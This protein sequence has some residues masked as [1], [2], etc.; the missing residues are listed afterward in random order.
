MLRNRRPLR[1]SQEV[2]AS[3]TYRTM[4]VWY[5]KSVVLL[6]SIILV[7]VRA[8]HG[9]RSRAVSVLKDCRGRLETGLL[10][11]AWL[12]FLVPLL[13][14]ATDL[15]QFADYTPSWLLLAAGSLLIL[16]G[17]WLFQ[18]SHA[19]L[20]TNWS[21]TLQLRENHRLVTEG[22]YRR[23]R[24]PMYSSFFLYS[25]GQLVA[26]PN[27]L[28]G[29]TYLAAFGLLYVFRVAAEERMMLDQFGDEYRAYMVR[30]KRLIPGVW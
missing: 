18:R 4:D 9:Q 15:F 30:T 13:W 24:H 11:L 1:H 10:I 27:W 3:L 19:D 8:P 6:A 26:V 17:L 14:V 29:P 7:A 28:V 2:A 12:G 16:F 20:G 21:V 23:I 22:I 5:P 25:I